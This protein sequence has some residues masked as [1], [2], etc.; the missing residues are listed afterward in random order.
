M[1]YYRTSQVAEIIGVHSNT[2]RLYEKNGL[3]PHAYRK[4]NGYRMFTEFHIDQFKLAR[5]ALEVEILQN[6]LRACSVEIIKASAEKEFD[7]ALDLAGKYVSQI[8]EEKAKAQ[9]A[10]A[11]VN[12]KLD[13]IRMEA[14]R[15][16]ACVLL[17]RK[18]TAAALDVT[19][20]TLRNWERNGLI[21]VKRNCR[22]YR[23]YN[24]KDIQRLKIIRSLRC[25]N[26]SLSS[27]LRMMNA[28]DHHGEV[29]IEAILNTPA[30]N[31]DIV[32][33]CDKLLSTL[34]H[35][36]VNA[37]ILIEKL[38]LFRQIYN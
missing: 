8:R 5:T 4:S 11:I 22:G 30:E 27:I 34:N 32:S 16:D 18:E 26:Y 12:K 24:S 28:L 9:E 3:I 15:D 17:K 1:N 23:M 21:T 19:I 29:N 33:A 38:T 36:E 7:L 10:L 35:A 20:D 14:D 31:E 13:S 2:V 37:M 6:G 25:A